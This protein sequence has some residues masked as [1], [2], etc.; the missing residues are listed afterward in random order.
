MAF[1][2]NPPGEHYFRKVQFPP[3]SP[4]FHGVG[5]F[6]FGGQLQE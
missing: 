3:Q 4:G 5:L 6:I 2:A 1:P